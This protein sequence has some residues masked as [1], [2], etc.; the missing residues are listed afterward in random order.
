MSHHSRALKK[1][2][3]SNIPLAQDSL[4]TARL[5]LKSAKALYTGECYPPAIYHLQQ[6]LEK[7]WKSFGFY[8]GIITEGQARSRDIIG[9]KGSK[10]CTRTIS[11]FKK[12][13]SRMRNQ[14][15]T[16]KTIQTTEP[17]D[18]AALMLN[19]ENLKQLDEGIDLILRD[20]NNFAAN[21]DAIRAMPYDEMKKIVDSLAKF[22]QALDDAQNRM[23]ND[24]FT[25]E[26][27]DKIRVGTYRF[28]RPLVTGNPYA[29]TILKK[30]VW[31]DLT[32]DTIREMMKCTLCAIAVT[33]PLF[34]LAVITQVHEQTTRYQMN[35]ISPESIYTATHPMIQLFPQIHAV[36]EITLTNLERLYSALPS[37]ELLPED[38]EESS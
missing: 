13:V 4:K 31:D 38:E 6:S 27:C 11:S 1:I 22:T 5:D 16:L 19:D 18:P 8:Y 24:L 3:K 34:Q 20:L 12:V 29:D 17:G 14:V 35:G 32:D 15:K 37:D 23:N 21:E 9:H 30:V 33:A 25:H 26:L 2:P 10:V 36:S 7:G 28:W